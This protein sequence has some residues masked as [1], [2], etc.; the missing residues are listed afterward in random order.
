M[1]LFIVI[2]LS[3]FAVAHPDGYY[4]D[5]KYEK[6]NINEIISVDNLLKAY[7]LCFKGAGKCTPEGTD[8]KRWIP[9]AFQTSCA[10]CTENQRVLVAKC[11]KAIA[12]K[13]PE[14]YS[15]LC[16]VYDPQK[17]HEVEIQKFIAKYSI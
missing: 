13:F 7:A 12:T 10:Q 6:F 14:D 3:A 11:L 17:H 8:F 4:Y 5:L 1:K 9:E 2:A 16:N 15:E